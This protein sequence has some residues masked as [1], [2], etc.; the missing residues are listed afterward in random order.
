MDKL[1]WGRVKVQSSYAHFFFNK[2]KVIQ[3]MLFGLKYHNNKPLGLHYGRQIGMRMS[4]LSAYNT[5][6]ALVPVP[7]HPKKA[8]IRGYNQSEI[9]AK[10]ISEN[11]SAKLD[12]DLIKRIKHSSSQ[13]KKN[14]FQRWENVDGIFL[15]NAKI[16]NYKHVAIIDDMITTGST[17]E[18]IIRALRNEN[19]DLS[20]SVITLAIAI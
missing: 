17:V 2:G 1:F 13:T 18:S 10:G 11:H 19:P 7:L 14:R 16:K 5:L 4:Q 8:F 20:I 15:V 9:I 6:D 3:E 12:T